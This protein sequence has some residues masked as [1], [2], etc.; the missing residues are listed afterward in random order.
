MKKTFARTA[1]CLL[2][3]ALLVFSLSACGAENAPAGKDP[4]NTPSGTDV[5]DPP[6][7]NDGAP[8][9][10][11][12]SGL[13]LYVPAEYDG[14]LQIDT[15]QDGTLFSVSEKASL[16]AAR[17]LGESGDGAGWLFAVSRISEDRLHELLTGDMS[18][19]EV[20]ARDAEGNYYTFD[21]PTDVRLV[22]EDNDA[23]MKAVEQ[24]SALNEWASG[25]K[26]S[27]LSENADILEPFTRGNSLLDMFLARAAYDAG[28]AYTVSTL[29][30]GPLE[31]G[32]VSGTPYAEKLMSGTGVS[33]EPC[34]ASETPDGEYAV[35]YFPDEDVRFDFFFAD[36][37]YVR[38]VW[39]G[40][41]QLTRIV[42]DDGTVKASDVMQAWYDE[43]VA[44]NGAPMRYSPD[45]MAGVWAEKIAGRCQIEITRA[46]EDG[47]FDV[48]IGWAGSAFE[49][50]FWEMTATE[51]GD[52]PVLTYT[53][54]RNYTRTYTSDSDYTETQGYTGGH[55]SFELTDEGILIWN[56]AQEN[57]AADCEFVRAD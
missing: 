10:Y 15:L 47:V 18:G 38:T 7:G 17:E 20:F 36:G 48:K 29:E 52:R 27:I 53:D 43:I 23:M 25:V 46:A 31:P 9:Q 49:R 50:S 51:D 39:S 41:E 54:C 32:E 5:Q 37:N 1:V 21:R 44:V 35:L 4:Q 3:A 24:W 22:R 28:A 8:S 13:T 45:D 14:L 30:Y 19:T 34:D 57:A 12:A 56:D 11:E 26:G 6:A 42:F 33:Y 40:N 16:D 2:L 55:G